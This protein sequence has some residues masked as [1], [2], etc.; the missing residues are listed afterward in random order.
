MRPITGL[1]FKRVLGYALSKDRVTAAAAGAATP[2][3]QLSTAERLAKRAK[4]KAAR[5]ARKAAR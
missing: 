4:A 1:P 5:K 3:A 2:P